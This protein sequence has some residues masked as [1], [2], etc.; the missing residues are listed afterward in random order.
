M[1]QL[2]SQVIASTNQESNK[3]TFSEAGLKRLFSQM[4]DPYIFNQGHDESLP[5]GGKGYNKRLKKL[6]NGNLAIIIDVDLYVET[7]EIPVGG[8]SLSTR[9]KEMRDASGR[10]PSISVYYDEELLGDEFG[11]KIVACSD[12][13]TSISAISKVDRDAGATAIIVITFV[14][15][16]ICAGFFQELGREGFRKLR[17]LLIENGSVIRGGATGA[18]PGYLFKVKYPTDSGDVDVLVRC[19]QS[20]LSPDSD[21]LPDLD[22][23]FEYLDEMLAVCRDTL[24]GFRIYVV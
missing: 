19:S 8:F 22:S 15:T 17:E 9:H 7:L 5:P 11:N 3:Q 24:F 10:A 6:S 1:R 14:S 20:Q 12:Q 4:S 2:K 18:E 13:E 16:A 21:K 23:L